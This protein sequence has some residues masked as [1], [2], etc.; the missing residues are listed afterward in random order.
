[1]SNW[2]S[3]LS[4]SGL[5]LVTVTASSTVTPA[6]SYVQGNLHPT[7]TPTSVPSEFIPSHKHD[8]GLSRTTVICLSVFMPLVGV[9]LVGLCFYWRVHHGDNKVKYDLDD[10]HEE[11]EHVKEILSTA[12]QQAAAKDQADPASIS[13]VQC[14]L[15]EAH[16]LN[17]EIRRQLQLPSRK[18]PSRAVQVLEESKSQRIRQADLTYLHRLLKEVNLENDRFQEVVKATSFKEEVTGAIS[19]QPSV[20]LS[21]KGFRTTG[22]E[23]TTSEG[24]SM[25]LGSE[26]LQLYA[27]PLADDQTDF[28]SPGQRVTFGHVA[29]DDMFADVEKESSTKHP[30]TMGKNLVFATTAIC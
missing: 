29:D 14:D 23:L 26:D 5:E 15:D 2:T 4:G 27:N 12:R 21:G 16:T 30:I 13:Q 3:A 18:I 8:H 28:G 22:G 10:K 6:S 9:M 25:L 1:M 24:V 19:R 20:N 7:S 17:N 11:D